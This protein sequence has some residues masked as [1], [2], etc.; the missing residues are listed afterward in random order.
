MEEFQTEVQPPTKS[1]LTKY[2]FGQGPAALSEDPAL[3][4]LF[5]LADQGG[6]C[7]ICEKLPTPGKST[8]LIRMVVD[9]EHVRGWKLMEPGRRRQYVRG[10]TCWFCNSTYLGR[11]INIFKASNVVA[12]L[13][14]Y[15]RRRPVQ[16]GQARP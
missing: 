14:A 13:T 11:S 1:T 4:W 2:G 12:Y 16:P 3:D 15:A 9:H 10:L 8:G 6:V 5:L 7:P